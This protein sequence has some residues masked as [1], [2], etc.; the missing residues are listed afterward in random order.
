MA[1]DKLKFQFD[2]K[3]DWRD[4]TLPTTTDMIEQITK[5]RVEYIKLPEHAKNFCTEQFARAMAVDYIH[6]LNV[7]ELVGTQSQ[8]DTKEVLKKIFDKSSVDDTG[9]GA[10]RSERETMNTYEALKL[11]HKK[12]E[13]MAD[14]GLL[15]V[16]E[17]CD[18]HRVLL[19]GVHADCGKIRTK[20]AYTN[21]HDGPHFY[22]SPEEAEALFYALID[23]HNVYMETCQL[24]E[25]SIEY[26]AFIFKCAARLLFEFVDTHPFGDGNGR[27]C[28]LLANYVVGLIT[29]FP[30]SLYHTQNQARSGRDDYLNAIVHCREH[31]HEGPRG[32]AAML[33][34]GAW[35]GWESLF[36]NLE[37]RGLLEPGMIM[38]PIVVVKSKCDEKYV[39]ERVDRIW[40]GVKKRKV[41]ARKEDVVK[42]IVGATK[43]TDVQ[44]LDGSKFMQTTV[45]VAEGFSVKLDIYGP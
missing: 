24:N 45:P 39:T 19:H 13:K 37:R 1:F 21:W 18:I 44:S 2:E 5:R 17:I 38:G 42:S 15:T 4:T 29:P 7:G 16:P 30:V 9:K 35:R 14:T 8:E 32:L 33:V 40:S 11:F 23:H 41:E 3:P 31:P 28:R 34:E 36:N 10:T 12:H 26:T 25:S 22:P 27:M 20:D 6:N 43:E